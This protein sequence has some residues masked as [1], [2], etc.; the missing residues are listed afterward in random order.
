[1]GEDAAVMV[2][3][4]RMSIQEAYNITKY[5]SRLPSKEIWIRKQSRCTGTS[6][7]TA[8]NISV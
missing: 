4:V 6:C 1:M 8:L 7:M 2:T 3:V 5:W